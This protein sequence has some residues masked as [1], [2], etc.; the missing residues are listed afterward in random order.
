[1][2]TAVTYPKKKRMTGLDQ[3]TLA[4]VKPF[5]ADALGVRVPDLNVN[6]SIPFH[7]VDRFNFSATTAYSVASAF[8]PWPNVCRADMTVNTTGGTDTWAVPATFGGI[9]QVTSLASITSTFKACRAAAHGIKL[10]TQVAP[11][12][13]QGNIHVC[14]VPQLVGTTTWQFPAS[15]SDMCSM[16]G[17]HRF[18]VASLINN[19]AFLTNKFLD[20]TA[21]EYRV[22][23]QTLGTTNPS[24]EFA[25]GWNFVFIAVENAYNTNAA[26]NQVQ[27]E[28]IMH[29]EAQ[30]ALNQVLLS[31]SPSPS[32]PAAFARAMNASA[33]ISSVQQGRP[34]EGTEGAADAAREARAGTGMSAMERAANVALYTAGAA[35]TRYFQTTGGPRYYRLRPGGRLYREVGMPVAPRP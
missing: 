11:G 27:V 19:P 10:T 9:A 17:Y 21:F 6:S 22:P 24:G 15:V 28:Q 2:R 32:N 33:H 8:F 30:P 16:P 35:V 3:F 13:A 34:Q 12:Y 23:T 4:Q 26:T 29:M 31:A 7:V 14:W 25:L 20:S 5:H 1:M 18:S